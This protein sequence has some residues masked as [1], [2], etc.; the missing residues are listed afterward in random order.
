LLFMVY[1]LTH[2]INNN[3]NNNRY[4]HVLQVIS[5][6]G[7]MC[8]S[9]TQ[10]APRDVAGDG[11]G[12]ATAPGTAT[13][14]PHGLRSRS[15]RKPTTSAAATTGCSMS[16]SAVP[17]PTATI[18]AAVSGAR[19]A[20][21]T[22]S[23]AAPATPSAVRSLARAA[24]G[25]RLNDEQRDN[26]CND[27][28]GAGGAGGLQNRDQHGGRRVVAGAHAKYQE[29]EAPTPQSMAFA[30]P[31][32]KPVGKGKGQAP[33]FLLTAVP[34]AHGPGG[35]DNEAASDGKLSA[36]GGIG[37]TRS[38]GQGSRGGAAREATGRAVARDKQ[39]AAGTCG[40]V[41]KLVNP[42]SRRS[43]RVKTDDCANA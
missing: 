19:A 33:K 10:Q 30:P 42:P 21:T 41:A 43:S 40:Q 17:V 39:A 5:E 18:S 35:E 29:G 14:H 34:L 31:G 9:D 22:D 16:F 24:A 28:H 26:D 1:A 6:L 15:G 32:S 11:R 13:H 36:G 12:H 25:T 38:S 8:S 7:R 27:L 20:G 4:T 23:A 3:N 37:K 2:P